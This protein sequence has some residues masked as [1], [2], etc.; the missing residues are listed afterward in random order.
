MTLSS[1]QQSHVAKADCKPQENLNPL[2]LLV[3]KEKDAGSSVSEQCV[4]VGHSR[5]HGSSVRSAREA[6]RPSHVF[7]SAADVTRD[8]TPTNQ[9]QRPNG[10]GGP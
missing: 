6:Q 4:R 7:V 3:R 5:I 2:L 1:K 10:K 9:D 8:G